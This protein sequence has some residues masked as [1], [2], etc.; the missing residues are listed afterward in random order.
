[1]KREPST[2][3]RLSLPAEQIELAL[4]RIENSDA[5]RNSP[6]HR[7]LL[8]HLVARSLEAD[9]AALKETVIAVEVFGRSAARFDPKLDTI[10]RV[11][12]RRLRAR[13]SDYY[14]TDGRDTALRIQLPVGSYVPLIAEREPP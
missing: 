7:A 13:L 1:M 14:R 4:A 6:R 8:R 2:P 9:H 12:A 5:F 10:V 3:E 11:E